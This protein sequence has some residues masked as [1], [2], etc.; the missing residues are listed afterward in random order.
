[1]SASDD[2]VLI[3]FEGISMEDKVDGVKCSWHKFVSFIYKDMRFRLDFGESDC[4]N[5]S[6]IYALSAQLKKRNCQTIWSG[7]SNNLTFVDLKEHARAKI[8]N[9]VNKIEREAGR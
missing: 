9:Y 7:K 4:A 2:N 6:L 8:V 5:R 3:R 1:M